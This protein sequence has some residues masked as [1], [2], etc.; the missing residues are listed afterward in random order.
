MASSA[1]V[2]LFKTIYPFLE[3]H[4][5]LGQRKRVEWWQISYY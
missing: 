3:L 5:E 4:F 2:G 1:F